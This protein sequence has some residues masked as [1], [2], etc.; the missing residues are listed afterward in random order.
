MAKWLHWGNR[1]KVAGEPP[2]R[3][4]LTD[5]SSWLLEPQGKPGW[6]KT[7]KNYAGIIK[8][9]S[10]HVLLRRIILVLKLFDLL[11]GE[12]KN[13]HFYDFGFSGRVPGSQN[14]FFFI[15]GETR[16]PQIIQ[17][18]TNSFLKYIILG[19]LAT[20]KP[21]LLKNGTGAGRDIRSIRLIKSWKSWMCD[22][23]YL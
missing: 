16:M 17:E 11:M 15:F 5:L 6:G 7:K 8:A 14:E 3:K 19:N 22:K 2:A 4:T 23:Y 21:I 13:P 10:I 9:C 18:K 12:P 20:H 1:R